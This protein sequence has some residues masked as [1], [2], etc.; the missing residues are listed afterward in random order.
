MA[1]KNAANRR[2]PRRRSRKGRNGP[3]YAAVDLGTNNCRL[4]VAEP[5]GKS[6]RVVDSHSQI[7]RLGEG[8]HETGRISDAA[9]DRAL[10]ALKAIR[11]KL[12]HHGVG[13]VRCIATEA[14]RKAEN[15]ADFIK[16][17]HDETGLTFKIINAKEEARLATIGCHDLMGEDAKTVLVVDIGG[18]STELS[19]V[20]ARIARDGGFEGLVERAPIQDWTSLPLGVVTLQE[21]FGHLPEEEAFPVMLGHARE[22]IE[23][24]KGTPRVRRA[25][26]TEGS[27]LIGTSGTV[28]CLAGVHLKLD[29][30]RRDKVDGTWLSRDEAGACIQLLRDLGPTGR[31]TLPTIGEER[32]G[33]MLSGCAIMQAV[34]DAFPGER[35]RVGDRGLRE[36]LLLSMMYGKKPS[37]RRS[38]R[39][40]TGPR[41]PG[42]SSPAVE[43]PHD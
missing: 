24:W 2:G 22:V 34:W 31:A 8:L 16:R 14:C 26:E 9:V 17:V 36:G 15:G 11:R 1:D 39:R 5:W 29:K 25:M 3:L 23:N 4:L 19:W 20:N 13:R 21:A 41:P 42:D 7:A 30:Y 33:L 32:A 18:G 6:F 40:R 28:T 43:A 12:K 38:G 27:H 10:D 37:R 35:M